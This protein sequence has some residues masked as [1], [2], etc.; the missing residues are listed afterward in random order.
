MR[1]GPAGAIDAEREVMRLRVS[2][3]AA[4]LWCCG[5]PR[6]LEW[7]ASSTWC[8]ACVALDRLQLPGRQVQ[9]VARLVG[10]ARDRRYWVGA[11]VVAST[12]A[13]VYAGEV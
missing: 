3:A 2:P 11:G 13:I 8:T 5:I 7:R 1:R 12:P 6:G 9:F 10:R 4:R